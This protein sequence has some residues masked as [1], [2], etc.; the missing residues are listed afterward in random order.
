[1]TS[2]TQTKK[3]M[4]DKIVSAAIASTMQSFFN[5]TNKNTILRPNKLRKII[6]QQKLPGTSWTQ[7]AACLEHVLEEDTETEKYKTPSVKTDLNGNII[8]NLGYANAP[9]WSPNGK[10][11]VYMNDKDDGHKLL[12]SDIYVISVDGKNRTRVTSTENG[13]EIYP[14]W[15]SSNK[16]LYGTT[17]G[18]IYSIEL[19]F[20]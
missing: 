19:K 14:A 12:S 2:S 5:G 1:M 17:E 11:V 20:E 13:I 4:D 8:A 6:C 10:Y 3:M 18:V 15:L 16:V 7:F 9:Q